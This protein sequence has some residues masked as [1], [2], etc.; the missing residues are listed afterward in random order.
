MTFN[1]KEEPHEIAENALKEAN[2]SRVFVE[3]R[4]IP[5]PS[6]RIPGWRTQ[7]SR[8]V[9]VQTDM[10]TDIYARTKSGL[11]AGI[12]TSIIFAFVIWLFGYITGYRMAV[13]YMS[14]CS[15]CFGLLAGRQVYV[16]NP[17]ELNPEDA[18]LAELEKRSHDKAIGSGQLSR[19][20]K[21]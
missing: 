14:V 20:R 9:T 12:L 7:L 19:S 15:I 3:H 2:I 17:E 4:K 21:R 8:N 5:H 10:N 16:S 1:A 11:L 18:V 13:T 6:S